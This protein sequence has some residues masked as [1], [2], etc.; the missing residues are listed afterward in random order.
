MAYP[1]NDKI[2]KFANK[3]SHKCDNTCKNF[4]FPHLSRAYILSEV[5]SVLKGEECYEYQK[6]I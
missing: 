4:A 5:Y 6:N 1:I 3:Q 2:N